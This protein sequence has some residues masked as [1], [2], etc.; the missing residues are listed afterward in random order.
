MVRKRLGWEDFWKQRRDG[1]GG[2][3]SYDVRWGDVKDSKVFGMPSTRSVRYTCKIRLQ[4]ELAFPRLDTFD[5][6]T[7]R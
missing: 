4:P 7:N 5:A 3:R 1:E 6:T 2:E